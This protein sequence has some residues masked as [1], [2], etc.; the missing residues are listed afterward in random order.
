MSNKRARYDRI[1]LVERAA[2]EEDESS[3]EED[4]ED[5]QEPEVQTQQAKPSKITVALRTGSGVICHVS[6][7]R[8]SCTS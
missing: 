6:V 4:E 5:E 8:R 2:D 3:E 7:G 1:A